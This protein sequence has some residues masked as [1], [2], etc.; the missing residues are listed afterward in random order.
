MNAKRKEEITSKDRRVVVNS[1]DGTK[2][3]FLLNW[4]NLFV[5]GKLEFFFFLLA[6]LALVFGKLLCFLLSIRSDFV[7]VY[8]RVILSFSIFVGL[9]VL[10]SFTFNQRSS[11]RKSIVFLKRQL[12]AE[13]TSALCIRKVSVPVESRICLN[14]P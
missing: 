9:R 2:I 13:I 8:M 1:D 6:F 5:K 11:Y 14:S 12:D 10:C 4:P 7:S 3:I